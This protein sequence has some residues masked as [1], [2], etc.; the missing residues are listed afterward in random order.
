MAVENSNLVTLY[1][2]KSLLEQNSVDLALGCLMDES[3][4][5]LRQAIFANEAEMKRFYGLVVNAVI[6][7]D[8]FDAELRSS[9]ND[10]WK[11]AFQ[12]CAPEM[13]EQ[14]SQKAMGDRKATV[15]IEHLMQ[16]SD[17]VHTMQ[18]W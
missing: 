4:T 2:G 1:S 3:F 16:A 12:E 10:R 15:I 11:L 14:A 8:L 6:A 9:R 13:P 17:V 5:E 7:T 18:H